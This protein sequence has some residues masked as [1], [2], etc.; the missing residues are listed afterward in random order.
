[1]N[2]ILGVVLVIGLWSFVMGAIQQLVGKNHP[3]TKNTLYIIVTI[4]FLI[5]FS[6]AFAKMT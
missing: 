1:M 4:S 2:I 6:I 3:K 5:Y